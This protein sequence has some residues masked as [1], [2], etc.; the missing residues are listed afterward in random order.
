MVNKI[1]VIVVIII[2]A[3]AGFVLALVDK[4][5]ADTEPIPIRNDTTGIVE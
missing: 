4:H 2:F 5:I 3:G 1:Y